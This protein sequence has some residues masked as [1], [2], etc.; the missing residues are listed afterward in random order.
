MQRR[1]Y[2]RA[3]PGQWSW[4]VGSEAG[5]AGGEMGENYGHVGLALRSHPVAFLRQDLRRRRIVSCTDAIERAITAAGIV[6]VRQRL[7][8][9]KGAMF[10]TWRETGIAKLVG[11][12]QVFEKNRR[13]VLSAGMI[14]AAAATRRQRH[15]FGRPAARR[16]VD[17]AGESRRSRRAIPT[18]AWTR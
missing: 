17:R 4:L 14:A 13:I 12:P 15:P 1:V 3:V 8:S 6:L 16:S 18:T 9:A 2:L 10:I 11:W 5:L 7:G